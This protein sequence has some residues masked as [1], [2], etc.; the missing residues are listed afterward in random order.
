MKK[1][2]AYERDL[3]EELKEKI[4]LIKKKMDEKENDKTNFDGV[5]IEN[6][7]EAA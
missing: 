3:I 2:F 4:E 7:K 6:S 1:Y 5:I